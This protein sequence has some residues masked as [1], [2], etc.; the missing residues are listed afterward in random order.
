MAELPQR[1]NSMVDTI[2]AAIEKEENKGLYLARLGASGIGDP[3]L[4]KTWLAWRAYFKSEFSGRMFRLFR[5]GHLQEDRIVEDL[6]R[7]GY[8]VWSH[9]EEGQQFAA[10]DDTGHFVVKLDG[11]VKGV[12]GAE[13][14]PHNL[15]IKTHSKKSFE[16]LCKKKVQEAKPVHYFQM[17]AGMLFHEL[18]SALYVALC[19]DD[20]AYYIERL[21]AD[22]EC[23]KEI[24]KRIYKLVNATIPPTGI[25]TDGEGFACK[26][27]DAKEACFGRVDPIRTC[28]SC[29]NVEVGQTGGEWVC[30]LFKKELQNKEQMTACENYDM[31]SVK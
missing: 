15:E 9:T 27:C 25:S 10:N 4:R 8:A 6:R 3:C 5:T 16:S 20:E 22:P 31:W 1:A 12:P 21:K 2:Y 18:P 26:W 17:Q 19:K 28:R 13:K 30:T 14:Q 11:I 23:Q 7:A 29:R 24:Q